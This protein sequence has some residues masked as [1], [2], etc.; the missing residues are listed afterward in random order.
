M[1]LS[2]E[3]KKKLSNNSPIDSRRISYAF[4]TPRCSAWTTPWRFWV[5]PVDPPINRQQELVS[6]A[7][8]I[9]ADICHTSLGWTCEVL[10]M[11]C[12]SDLPWRGDVLT[13]KTESSSKPAVRRKSSVIFGCQ[14]ISYNNR[15][16]LSA[17][18]DFPS[19][20]HCCFETRNCANNCSKKKTATA[21]FC[22]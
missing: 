10:M 6:E 2:K 8:S 7:Y 4:E 18:L 17:I 11:P 16:K 5:V 21:E 3:K 15:M 1:T 14:C 22:E 12:V 20:Y 19:V 13:M 9:R